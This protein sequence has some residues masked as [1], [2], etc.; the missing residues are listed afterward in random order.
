MGTNSK[1]M[2]SIC[3]LICFCLADVGKEKIISDS[4]RNSMVADGN[5]D[6]AERLRISEKLISE[7]NETWEEKLQKA[8]QIRKERS[9]VTSCLHLLFCLLNTVRGTGL[10]LKRILNR[11]RLN[12]LNLLFC[13]YF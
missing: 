8:E 11:Y 1:I 7:L 12:Q 2:G 9:V 10:K 4:R 13:K 6:A 5:E 3:Y